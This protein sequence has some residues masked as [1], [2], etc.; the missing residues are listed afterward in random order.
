M[1]LGNP[2]PVELR[3]ETIVLENGTLKIYRDVYE[4]GTNTEENL[5]RVLETFGVSL[6]DLE[7]QIKSQIMSGLVAMA[8]DAGGNP[9]AENDNNNA[10]LDRGKGSKTGQANNNS[11]RVTRDI[12]GKKVVEFRIPELAG[13]GYPAPV[14]A[15]M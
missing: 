4:K 14:G 15:K 3:Y 7:P 2:V 5:R 9:V 8:V 12:K 11:G 13:K 10:N 6:D 1:K